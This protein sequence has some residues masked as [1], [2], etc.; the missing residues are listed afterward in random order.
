MSDESSRDRWQELVNLHDD[1]EHGDA[2]LP[3]RISAID[4]SRIAASPKAVRFA[5][6][7]AFNAGLVGHLGRQAAPPRATGTTTWPRRKMPTRLRFAS[8]LRRRGCYRGRR[9]KE[10]CGEGLI[11]AREPAA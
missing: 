11:L 7:L 8:G 9:I 4:G 5:E 1:F 6:A 10:E 2:V 3:T